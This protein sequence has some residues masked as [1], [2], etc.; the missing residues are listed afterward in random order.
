MEMPQSEKDFIA[1]FVNEA[2]EFFKR[3]GEI[4]KRCYGVSHARYKKILKEFVRQ[5][6]K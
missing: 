5:L 2:G 1:L 6:A 3:E 4:A